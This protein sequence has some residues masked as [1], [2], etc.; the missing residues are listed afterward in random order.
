MKSVADFMT[1]ALKWSTPVEDLKL[2]DNEVHVW[3]ANLNQPKDVQARLTKWLSNDEIMRANRFRSEKNR[4]HFIAARGVLRDILSRYLKQAPDTFEF[5]ANPYGKPLLLT[6]VNG[7]KLSFN[8]SHSGEYALYA[9]MYDRQIGVDIEQIRPDFTANEI[10]QRFF[11]PREVET[12][13]ALPLDLQTEAFFA[14]WTR[15]E[16]FIKAKGKGLSIPLQQFD[17]TLSPSEPVRLLQTQWDA[18]EA[19]RWSLKSLFVASNYAAAIAVEGH[20]WQLKN[21]RWH[22]P[23]NTFKEAELS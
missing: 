6:P 21:W 1:P 18:E 3:F 10:A 4:R 12:L 11:S 15:K 23:A 8:V 9:V 7:R 13:Q 17:V 2:S 5:E 22:K 19:S 16:A 14:C 20:E